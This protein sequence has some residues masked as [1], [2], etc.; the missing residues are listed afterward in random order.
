MVLTKREAQRHD[1][2]SIQVL[3]QHLLD[4]ET[5]TSVKSA[6]KEYMME[7]N[8]EVTQ[9]V[10]KNHDVGNTLGMQNIKKSLENSFKKSALTGKIECQKVSQKKSMCLYDTDMISFVRHQGE[11][12]DLK[13]IEFAVQGISE[14]MHGVEIFNFYVGFIAYSGAS[15]SCSKS[16]LDVVS[17]SRSEM[18]ARVFGNRLPII[19]GEIELTK[20]K[21]G[22]LHDRVY[23]NVLGNVMFDRPFLPDKARE[24]SIYCKPLRMT[25]LKPTSKKLFRFTK[26]IVIKVVPITFRFS[27]SGSFGIDLVIIA[28]PSRLTLTGSIEP[29][30]SIGVSGGAAVGVSGFNTGYVVEFTSGYRIK[31]GFG[32]SNCNL[33]AVLDHEIRPFK[34]KFIH[35]T[36]VVAKLD[37]DLFDIKYPTIHGNLFTKCIFDPKQ[38]PFKPLE[39]I[40]SPSPFKSHSTTRYP[41]DKKERIGLDVTQE[42]M[43]RVICQGCSKVEC[44]EILELE[45]DEYK[46]RKKYYDL[47]G[48]PT[49]FPQNISIHDEI[50]A[51]NAAKKKEKKKQ[52]KKGGKRPK[53]RGGLG[54]RI[55]GLGK[56]NGKG[57]KGGLSKGKI[58]KGKILK[59]G[60]GGKSKGKGKSIVKENKRKP[61][62]GLGKKFGNIKGNVSKKP[63]TKKPQPQNPKLSKSEKQNKVEKNPN[64]NNQNKIEKPQKRNQNKV[65]KKP[66][67]PKDK[68]QKKPK[69]TTQRSKSNQNNGNKNTN[70][71]QNKSK[72]ASKQPT[73]ENDQSNLQ[74]IKDSNPQ[75]NESQ[76]TNGHSTEENHE[77]NQEETDDKSLGSSNIS[78]YVENADDSQEELFK[79]TNQEYHR[80]SKFSKIATS[81][82]PNPRNNI[83]T[84]SYQQYINSD[85]ND[86][87]LNQEDKKTE[88]EVLNQI[89]KPLQ[90]GFSFTSPA[91]FF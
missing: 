11:L 60:K 20:R 34:M 68:N 49:P 19:S 40:Q 70:K 16:R 35:S 89:P 31:P 74:I 51:K 26:T 17:F 9:N 71:S 79:E 59:G 1:E 76:E 72:K 62:E 75:K 3:E 2:S 52:P 53:R 28:C 12:N 41:G 4:N 21:F 65:E 55:G 44:G 29:Y 25:I 80:G 37:F 50:E 86:Y 6:I 33:C 85:R 58:G 81:T 91:P 46:F 83:P 66:N 14:S 18:K 27:L 39:V 73:K 64:R 63:N 45:M 36:Q 48:R 90:K 7:I 23:L 8:N 78:Q 30:F 88:E 13:D 5:P 82:N 67:T 22:N 87:R 42:M 38:R 56:G 77:T 69:S 47:I 15:M 43:D 54:K 32:T 24:N 57:R 84:N 61:K 10:L